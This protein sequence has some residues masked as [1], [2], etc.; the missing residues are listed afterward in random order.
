M[1]KPV[2]ITF[3]EIFKELRNDRRF[4]QEEL[5]RGLCDRTQLVGLEH[6]SNKLV[7]L[8]FMMEVAERMNLPHAYIFT[9]TFKSF[10]KNYQKVNDIVNCLYFRN[11]KK[12]ET[13]N[14]NLSPDILIEKKLINII[15]GYC[16]MDK[17]NFDVSDSLFLE[18]FNEDVLFD[19]YDVLL[20][21]GFLE[22]L[23]ERQKINNVTKI[24]NKYIKSLIKG[25]EFYKEAYPRAMCRTYVLLADYFFRRMDH[26]T[27]QRYLYEA[28]LC[29]PSVKTR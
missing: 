28:F 6:G 10:D 7:D 16:E 8:E 12:L 13:L 18:F 3:G 20:V 1:K 22:G 29:N 26:K 27:S 4:T 5:C 24:F 2:M 14:R 21:A 11:F 23:L 25:V 19:I 15:I 9:R 17:E